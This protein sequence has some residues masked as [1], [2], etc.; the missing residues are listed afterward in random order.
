MGRK[1]GR[2]RSTLLGSSARAGRGLGSLVGAGRLRGSNDSI[3]C[4]RALFEGIVERLFEEL[5]EEEE[6]E[7]E[8]MA[9]SDVLLW[10]RCDVVWKVQLSSPSIGKSYIVQCQQ[11]SHFSPNLSVR[12][13]ACTSWTAFAPTLQL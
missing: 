4:F 2:D 5:N 1:A 3:C 11:W 10:V 6:K 7:E 12:R 9:T 8:A 13:N